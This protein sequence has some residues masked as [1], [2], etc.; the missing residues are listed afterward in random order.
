MGLSVKRVYEPAGAEDGTR[1]LVDRYWPRGL[2]KEKAQIDLWMK[3]LAPSAD[4]I[5][6]FGHKPERWEEFQR[7]Y[8]EELEST[9]DRAALDELRDRARSGAVTLLFGARDE[10]SN[11]AV[12]L[13]EYLRI[14]ESSE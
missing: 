13:A 5:S 12:A 14:K 4:L 7:R 6:W 10:Q 1:V 3:Q 9:G 11:N 8:R 2:S